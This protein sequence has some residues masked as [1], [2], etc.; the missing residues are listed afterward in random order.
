MRMNK[1]NNQLVPL[2]YINSFNFSSSTLPLTS[3]HSVDDIAKGN[4]L[5]PI[6]TSHSEF[7]LDSKPIEA[8]MIKQTKAKKNKKSFNTTS[9]HS[10]NET[11]IENDNEFVRNSFSN[12]S[13]EDEYNDEDNSSLED[14]SSF[15]SSFDEIETA[16]INEKLLT[17]N[18]N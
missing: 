13:L 17:K 9:S 4:K 11:E 15:D 1:R 7:A 14:A 16:E 12:F 18:E 6:I 8:Y 3:P 2:M 10:K 5:V